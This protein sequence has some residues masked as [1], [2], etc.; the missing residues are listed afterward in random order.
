MQLNE[1]IIK[2]QE[3]SVL[4]GVKVLS[5]VLIL[6]VGRIAAKI[7][8]S[9]TT[10][11]MQKSKVDETII[12]F[13]NSLIYIGL[14]A[15][16]I[17]AA[18]GKLGV[19][20]TSFVAILGAAG[21]AI[22]LALQGSLSNFAAGVLVIIF[23]PVKVGDFV[24]AG[25]ATGVVKEVGIFTTILA[26][27][28]NK[29]IIVPNAKLTGDNIINYNCNGT[30]RVDLIA[31]ISY[32]DDIDKAK[33]ILMDILTADKRILK[34]PAPMVG[35]V[36]MADSSINLVVRPWCNAAD[37]W[38]IFF[39]VQEQIKKRFD[40]EGIEIPFPQQDIHLHKVEA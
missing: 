32:N 7:V 28:D 15:F 31:G 8:R 36:E 16:V 12:S 24:E 6:L 30:R 34:D 35:V 27:P 3:L 13:V 14:M 19:Q 29:K 23:K 26:S 39:D 38:D 10:K 2:L 22:G 17:V 1:V 33:K 4:Y 21:L 37:Y 9:I 11:V 40:T 25:G 5:A 18:I 20:T